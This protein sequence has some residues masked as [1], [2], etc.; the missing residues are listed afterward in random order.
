MTESTAKSTL[1]RVSSHF[2][3]HKQIL[4]PICERTR[5]A[6]MVFF[7]AQSHRIHAIRYFQIRTK[8]LIVI[9]NLKDV[10]FFLSLEKENLS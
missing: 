2:V 8:N 3:K 6:I 9:T 10:L 5:T 4:N 7:R 1:Y